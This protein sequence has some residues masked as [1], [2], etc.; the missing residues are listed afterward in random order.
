MPIRRWSRTGRALALVV[1]AAILTAGCKAARQPAQSPTG[2]GPI[3]QAGSLA[4]PRSLQQGGVPA[5]A[6]LAAIPASNPQTPEK[7]SLGE[8]LFF[9]GRLSQDGTVACSTCHD[10]A[11]AFTDGRPLATGIKGR[12]GQRNSPTILNALYNKFQF[13]DGRAA[14]LEDQAMLPIQNP[15][16]MGQPSLEAAVDAVARAPEYRQ[17]FQKVFGRAPNGP[18]LARAI[19]SYER[20]QFA[21]G[22]PFDHFMAGDKNAISDSAKR[23][24]E[25]F[26]SK[27]RC[28]LCHAVSDTKRDPTFFMDQDVHNIGVGIIRHDVVALACQAEA[29]LNSG[30]TIAVD[31]AAITSNLSVLGRFLVTKKQADIAA[32][33]TPSLRNVLITSPYFHDGS[34]RTLWDVMDHYNKGDGVKNPWLDQDIQPLGLSETEIDDVVAFMASLTSPQYRDQGETELAR[35]REIARTSRTQRDTARAFGPKPVQPNPTL[36]CAR[37]H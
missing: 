25:L 22:S 23:G 37:A 14:T 24:W 16:E 26:N 18:D 17:A 19:A 32:F 8:K 4:A 15:F 36:A 7:I 10:P 9:E 35:Q 20:T 12:V 2:P 30:D 6:T 34:Q 11:K 21:F 1:G 33:K 13:W 27:A 28:N 29:K 3:P 31:Q 5:E